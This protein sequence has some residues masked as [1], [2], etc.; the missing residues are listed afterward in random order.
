MVSFVI[1]RHRYLLPAWG[2]FFAC[3]VYFIIKTRRHLHNFTNI[4]NIVAACLVIIPLINITVYKLN[5]RVVWQDIKSTEK[6]KT[7]TIYLRK[8]DA[9]R[10]IYYIILDRYASTSTLKEIY[11]F[12]NSKFIDYLSN[13]GFYVAS[14]SRSNYLESDQSLASSLNMEFINHL[15]E[16]IGEES[17]YRMP[18]FA[19]LQDYKVWRFLKSKGYKFI[20]FGS[21]W[22]PTRK[23]R[24]ADLNFNFHS[25]PGFLI[26]LY[27]NTM[28]WPIGVKLGIFNP[29]QEH[30]KRVLYKFDKLAEIPNI[31]EPTFVFAHMI[32]PHDPYVFDRNGNFLREEEV[33]KRSKIVNYVDQL[34]FTNKKVRVLIDKLLSN[35]K[36]PPIII[37]QADEGPYPRRC[38][39][40]D[41]NFNWKQANK[42]E[43]REKLGIL[44][45]YYLP[46]ADKNVLYP[47]ITPVNSFRLIF[48]LYFNTHLELLPDE[49]YARVDANHP[50]KFFSVTDKVKYD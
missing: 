24:Y 29:F 33:K 50:Y 23:N 16:K 14:E 32:I 18:I 10:D 48:N 47:S 31:K 21:Y 11:N 15:S 2:I 27:R 6:I 4:L 12:D 19:L 49:S 40:G 39:Q 44:N 13:R 26:R 35:S 3:S 30:W 36:V 37:L 7:S 8:A 28:F 9:L 38:K 45:A 25:P 34:I 17:D 20:H 46:D 1:G 42:I 5:T 41:K 22:G 43:L